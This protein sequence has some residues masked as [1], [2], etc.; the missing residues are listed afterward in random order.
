[1][2]AFRPLL[3]RDRV[4]SSIPVGMTTL[5]QGEAELV[6]PAVPGFLWSDLENEQYKPEISKKGWSNRE[7]S[8]TSITVWAHRPSKD[9][10]TKHKDNLSHNE[11][12]N[13]WSDYTK[14][15]YTKT[16]LIHES[17]WSYLLSCTV[18]AGC[19]GFRAAPACQC[20]ACR[21]W[22]FCLS[23]AQLAA[24]RDG[25]LAAVDRQHKTESFLQSQRLKHL[26]QC[27]QIAMH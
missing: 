27:F 7:V 24:H 5:L 15:R 10:I 20:W 11:M 22:S 3:P 6:L 26:F 2:D 9:N 1:M 18:A 13:V 17:Q 8:V 21:Q 12:K 23:L 19:R 16:W 4:N 25:Y 14:H